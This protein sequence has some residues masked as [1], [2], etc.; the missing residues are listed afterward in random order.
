MTDYD[1][2]IINSD[3]DIH[4]SKCFCKSNNISISLINYDD[5]LKCFKMSCTYNK[6]TIR[7]MI[8]IEDF[9]IHKRN[10]PYKIK[11][12]DETNKKLFLD[13]IYNDHNKKD[14]KICFFKVLKDCECYLKLNEN[15]DFDFDFEDYAENYDSYQIESYIDQEDYSH[16]LYDDR[17]RS[18]DRSIDG[19]SSDG[20]IDE[21]S[22]Y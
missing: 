19:S 10:K 9:L 22:Y 3:Q 12:E 7:F 2:F 14:F 4:L 21:S 15:F 11:F 17:Y 8:Q 18:L 1:E 20:S 5:F 16:G 6:Y 13:K